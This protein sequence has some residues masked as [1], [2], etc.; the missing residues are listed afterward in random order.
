MVFGEGRIKICDLEVHDL[1]E[2]GAV[3]MIPRSEA[4][5]VSSLFVISK[6]G[7]G[8]RPIS[9]LKPINCYVERLHY[10]MEGVAMLRDII[11]PGDYFTKLDLKDAYLLVPVRKSDQRYLQFM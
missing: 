3:Q 5:F 10:K 6:N 1:V 11:Q 9:N 8:F 2:N 7:G 4:K